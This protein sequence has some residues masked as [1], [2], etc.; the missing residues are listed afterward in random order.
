[1]FMIFAI[2]LLNTVVWYV[3]ST[4]VGRFWSERHQL[5]GWTQFMLWC[6]AIM[7]VCG[8]TSVLVTVI[9]LAMYD[10]HA[11]EF[12]AM[13]LFEVE[14]T[15]RDVEGLVMSVFNAAYLGIVFPVI[16]SGL[17]ITINS[18]IVAAARRDAV[19]IGI[20]IYNT[21][22][23]IHNMVSAARHVPEAFEGLG[24]WFKDLEIDSDNAKGY[25]LLTLFLLP[26]IVSLGLAI[27]LTVLVMRASDAKYDL[28]QIAE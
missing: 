26:L 3:N 11:F 5:P 15:P 6:G 18:W 8:L 14:L 10:L 1:M 13:Q 19:S 16:G 4:N 22:A 24:N 17:A 23:Q 2:L 9:T 27:L 25:A 28:D 21:G 7:A 12:L 20:G